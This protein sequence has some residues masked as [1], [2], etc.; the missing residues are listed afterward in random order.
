MAL[1]QETMAS[2][3]VRARK[4]GVSTAGKKSTLLRRLRRGKGS[5]RKKSKRSTKKKKRTGKGKSK[6][7]AC[8]SMRRTN[9]RTSNRCS[10][11]PNKGCYSRGGAKKTTKR[12]KKAKTTK[13]R[14]K[15]SRKQSKV[16]KRGK[17]C[18]A[19]AK[20]SCNRSRSCSWK[21]GQ[22]CRTLSRKR[23]APRKKNKST[24]KKKTTTRRRSR[25]RK[26]TSPGRRTM[27]ALFTPRVRK[28][29]APPASAN[30]YPTGAR[31][32]GTDGKVYRT[33]RAYRGNSS[34]N[35]WVKV[36]GQ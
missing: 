11:K 21:V 5:T 14:G 12:K 30:L 20:G 17:A 1:G 34:Y 24:R 18:S 15:A 29:N 25:A 9:C 28:G 7:K 10:W 36:A 23:T 2:L 32:L 19:K 27:R 26:P 16:S 35:R 22:G 31:R 4:I 33:I 13:K 8:S 3:R 6:G